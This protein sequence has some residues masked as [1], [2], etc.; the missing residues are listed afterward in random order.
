MGRFETTKNA[1]D[2]G[3]GSTAT[4][5]ALIASK[6]NEFGS[7]TV[8]AQQ[9][10]QYGVGVISNGVDSRQYARIRVDSLAG[11]I[12]GKIRLRI[13]DSNEN[14]EVTVA[15]GLTSEWSST[16]GKLLGLFPVA[17]G[18][19]DK[20]KL[21]IYPDS[22]TTLDYSDADNVVSIPVTVTTRR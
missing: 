10:I 16:N 9:A 1:A 21:E 18:E 22:S 6:W 15:E 11:Q 8:P 14:R 2:F 3:A 12:T 19:D 17:A 7:L 5:I 13:S 4:D 20:L